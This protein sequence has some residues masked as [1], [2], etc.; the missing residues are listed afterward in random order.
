L[1]TGEV[2]GSFGTGGGVIGLFAF[3]GVVTRSSI[4]DDFL[5]QTINSVIQGLPFSSRWPAV[6]SKVALASIATSLGSYDFLSS[7]QWRDC[8]ARN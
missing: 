2:F 6:I 7:L 8:Q 5:E 4:R 3:K 1:F